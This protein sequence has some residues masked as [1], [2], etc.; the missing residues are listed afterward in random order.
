MEKQS[1]RASIIIV[2]YNGLSY[3]D[4]CL[5]S[6][7]SQTFTDYEV[8]FVDNASGDGSL[9]YARQKYPGLDF[10]ANPVNTGY[11][12]GVN[13][14]LRVARGEYIVPLNMDTEADRAWL[15][16]LVKF[17]D[18]HP[19]AGAACPK[20]L[21]LGIPGVINCTGLK[22]HVSGLG[23]C[24]QL[25]QPDIPQAAPQRVNGISGCSYI[26][27]RELF[28]RMGGAPEYCFMYNDDVVISWLLMLMGYD[29]YM[30]PS[31]I[32]YHRYRLSMTPEKFY[33]LEKN[34]IYLILSTLRW[35]TLVLLSP[36]LLAI[37]AMTFAYT[38]IKGWPYPRS[39]LGA[40]L[41]IFRERKCIAAVRHFNSGLRSISDWSLLKKLSWN[42][43]WSQLFGIVRFQLREGPRV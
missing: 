26:I 6:V 16:E 20:V 35:Y 11:A 9:E 40:Y 38:I 7:L 33:H 25:H 2:N 34:R 31:S 18:N 43:E 14:G 42:L 8:I 41:D 12:G 23:F 37:E 24:R 10:I 13:A 28:R 29:I 4:T 21:V 27:R 19:Q 30:V 5:A 15:A 32:I 3:I 17:M 22:L 36:L 39:K 1:P